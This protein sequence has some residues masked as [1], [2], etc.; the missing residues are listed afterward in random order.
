MEIERVAVIGTGLMGKGIC[1]VFAAAGYKVN[2]FGRRDDVREEILGY[3][4]NEVKKGRVTFDRQRTILCNIDIYNINSQ[5][6]V[7]G[8]NDLIIETVK[9]DIKAKEGVLKIISEYMKRDTIVAS[10][11]SS[12]TITNLAEFTINPRNFLGMDFFSPVPLMKL[13]EIVKGVETD[14]AVLKTICKIV[15]SMDKLPIQVKDSPGFVLNRGLLMLINEAV[16]MLNEGIANSAADIDT[17]FLNGMGLK[18]GPLKL[19]DLIGIDVVY[20]AIS[21]MHEGFV[22]KKYMPCPLLKHMVDRGKLGKKTM[23]GF[24]T[25]G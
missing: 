18:I 23:E 5:A 17:I 2:V 11:T 15:E 1:H 4:D 25:Y 7:L 8:E 6:E 14:E 22:D 13:V 24:Y 3:F 16:Y 9:E 20:A 10:N 12:Y 19:A 21:N